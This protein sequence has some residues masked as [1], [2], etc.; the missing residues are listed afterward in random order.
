LKAGFGGAG[1]KIFGRYPHA[2]TFGGNTGGYGNTGRYRN[3][4]YAYQDSAFIVSSPIKV[5]IIRLIRSVKPS[6]LLVVSRAGHQM[7]AGGKD[8]VHQLLGNWDVD[9]IGENLWLKFLTRY[10][11]ISV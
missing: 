2:G 8:L 9:E 7:V 5:F 10:N 3:L 1:G 11:K 6:C 4:P